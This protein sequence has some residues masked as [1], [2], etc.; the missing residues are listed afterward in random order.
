ML[1]ILRQSNHAILFAMISKSTIYV[2][3]DDPAVR[4]S[5][6]DLLS[7]LGFAVFTFGSASDYIASTKDDSVACLLLDIELPD[8]NGLDLQTRLRAGQHPPIIFITGRGDIPSSV[9]A[10]KAGAID[11][12]PKPFTHEQL[13]AAI[14]VALQQDSDCRRSMADLA[15]L[16]VRHAALSPREREVMRLVVRGLLNKQAAA[17]LG[18]SEVTLQIHRGRVMRKMAADS[19]ADLVRM[20][21]KLDMPD[22]PPAQRKH[23]PPP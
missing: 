23:A 13:L 8:I 21:I 22:D 17:E 1:Y 16:R 12:L 2:V 6:E 5:M 10:I 9:R 19:F 3:D 20:S 4:E 18:I 14:Q 7:S 11:F 15:E